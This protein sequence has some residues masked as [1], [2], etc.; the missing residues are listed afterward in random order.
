MRPGRELDT[1]IAQ[2]IFGH[3][4]VIKRKVPTEVTPSGERPLREYSKEIGAAFDV[5]KKLNISLI[6]I[7]GGQW[8]ALKGKE[9]GFTS[10]ANFIEYLSAGNFVDA[11]AAVTE[12]PSLSIC[13]AAMKAVES[14]L[15]TKTQ[16]LQ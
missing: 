16:D 7:E 15:A 10:P 11:G 14:K 1:M 4:V 12:S 9:E 6:P 13:L 3:E 5:A 8:F 2:H